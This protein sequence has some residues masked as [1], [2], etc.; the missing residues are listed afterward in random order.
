MLRHKGYKYRIYPNKMQEILITRTIGCS[1]FVYNHFLAKWNETYER[2]GKGLTYQTCSAELPKM[3]CLEATSW[4]KEVDSIA[5]QSS[6]KCL[7]DAFNRF[8]KKQNAKPRF[9]SKSNP[10]QSYLTKNVNHS[11]QLSKNYIKLP[12]L[13]LV[14]IK[15]SQYPNGRII[16][17]TIRKTPTGKYFV[18]LLV[19]EEI[20]T[21]P[22]T[23]VSVGIDLGLSNFAILSTGETIGNER[24]LKALS[25]KLAMEQ[26]K[27]SRRALIAKK[28]HKKLSECMNYQKQRIKVARIHERIANKRQDF[29]NKLS[30]HIIK[31]HDIICMEDLSSKNLMKNHRLA[32]AIGD[33]SWSEFVRMLAYKAEWYDKQIV[34]IS[35]WYPSSQIC[36]RCGAQSGKK[37]LH[38]R[39]WTCE[40][41]GT[42]HD[43]DVNAS[44]NILQEGL[45]IIS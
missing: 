19:E 15:S 4:L 33:V 29:L 44:I 7:A 36:S 41:C 17:A 45:R 31:N 24:F 28:T 20:K 43:R 21:Y 39:E 38:I 30:T 18:S 6:I 32:K 34:K 3:K 37:P 22:K 5:L 9:K 26:K 1:R 27:L 42:H 25:K 16:H 11:I 13:G 40:S 12:K 8:F 23:G 2:T 35:R 10:V 14:K